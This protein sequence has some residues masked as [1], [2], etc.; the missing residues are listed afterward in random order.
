MLV[1]LNMKK[2]LRVVLLI[3]KNLARPCFTDRRLLCSSVDPR[4]TLLQGLHLVIGVPLLDTQVLV[5]TSGKQRKL[6]VPRQLARRQPLLLMLHPRENSESSIVVQAG[7][8]ALLH[9]RGTGSRSH[10]LFVSAAKSADHAH[11]VPKV[12]VG[13]CFE[14]T[15]F[16]L[17]KQGNQK[18]SHNA[19]GESLR[20][21]APVC[22]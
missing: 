21:E 7:R 18:E 2:H 22:H 13:V 6:V 5:L 11:L 17:A 1:M 20:K 4:D 10:H 8:L 19:F 16:G 14:N 3:E 9:L 15:P 12:H